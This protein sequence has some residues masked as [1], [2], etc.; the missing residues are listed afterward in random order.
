[1]SER[2]ETV[3]SRNKNIHSFLLQNKKKEKVSSAD[4]IEIISVSLFAAMYLIS[5]GLKRIL[6]VY[7]YRVKRRHGF[8]IL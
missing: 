7:K 1:V 8:Y 3:F 2:S 6:T 5:Y 4:D